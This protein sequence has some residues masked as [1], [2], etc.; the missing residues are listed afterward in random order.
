VREGPL[1]SCS[2]CVAGACCQGVPA[3]SNGALK[4]TFTFY[5]TYVACMHGDVMVVKLLGP[6][7]SMHAAV[8]HSIMC[9]PGKPLRALGTG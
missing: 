7:C 8:Q 5:L 6:I 9:D 2:R 1:A 4:L 3:G